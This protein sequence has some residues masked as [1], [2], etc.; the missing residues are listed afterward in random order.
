MWRMAQQ[1]DNQRYAMYNIFLSVPLGLVR[2]L[3]VKPVVLNDEDDDDDDAIEATLDPAA[4][5]V[6]DAGLSAAAVAQAAGQ[7]RSTTATAVS[8][9]RKGLPDPLT[10]LQPLGSPRTGLGDVHPSTRRSLQR[11][12]NAAL[13]LVWPYVLWGVLVVALNAVRYDS[14]T[15]M[16]TPISLLNVVDIAMIRFHRCHLSCVQYVFQ[17][18]SSSPAQRQVLWQ[19]L[20]T[21]VM[22][23]KEE[24][25]VMVNGNKALTPTQLAES[26]HFNLAVA[27]VATPGSEGA[28]ILYGQGPV[29]MAI[30]ADTCLPPEHPYYQYTV[31]EA[32][33]EGGMVAL[34][35]AFLAMVKG[36]YENTTMLHV[37]QFVLSVLLA[38]AFY[39]FMLRPFL[40][41]TSSESRRIAELLAQLPPE[42]EVEG[43]VV[44]AIASVGPATALG[45]PMLSSLPG[46]PDLGGRPATSQMGE[47]LRGEPGAKPGALR[48]AASLAARF[49]QGRGT[50]QE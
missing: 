34:N 31:N 26:P 15:S 6:A 5:D 43:L 1:V 4:P 3:V 32:D 33:L 16:S 49:A 11:S 2:S 36:M 12:Y 46:A 14:L 22:L 37:V 10:G 40:R 27:G 9:V 47:G 45:G 35:A 20:A 28:A 18:P 44:K 8:A 39:I 7:G 24:W 21:E 17:A 13:W 48:G 25:E 30:L 42:L 50:S 19:S 41:E 23:L 29:C 38:G